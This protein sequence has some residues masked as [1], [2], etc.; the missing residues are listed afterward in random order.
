MKAVAK[1]WFL[2]G[3][4]LAAISLFAV[5][6]AQESSSSGDEPVKVLGSET[7]EV[8]DNGQSGLLPYFSSDRLPGK[9]PEVQTVLIVF[10]GVKR[11]ADDYLAAGMA[12][13]DAAHISDGLIVIAPQF[14]NTKDF[15]AYKLP[16]QMLR[17]KAAEWEGGFQAAGP[18]PMSSFSAIDGLL[19]RLADRSSFPNLKRVV[20]AGHSGGAQLVQRY[21]VVGKADTILKAGGIAIRYVVANPSSYLYFDEERPGINGKFEKYEATK[22]PG[23]N[24][25]KFGWLKAPPYVSGQSNQQLEE[26]FVRKNLIYLLG[27]AD[28]DPN[29]PALD[30]S[31]PAEAQG[32][33]RFA[34][35]TAYFNYLKMRHPELVQRLEQVPGIGHDGRA[36][37]TSA[38]G[39][40]ALFQ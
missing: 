17:W 21:A 7:I 30:K 3:I 27:T 11:N 37:F 14:L 39:L 9:S 24:D 10:H 35:G 18:V 32:P 1:R 29:H 36:M 19:R 13:K 33:T 20:L 6:R 25:W 26:S 4:F 15:E 2:P 5:G 23:F 28:T 38:V 34:R 8:R 31:C 12:A 22:C 40:K 16:N